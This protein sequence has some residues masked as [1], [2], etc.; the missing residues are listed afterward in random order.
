LQGGSAETHL[1]TA[2]PAQPARVQTALEAQVKAHPQV[3]VEVPLQAQVEV[4]L[5]AQVEV[6]LK[7]QV[8]V[9]RRAQV[10]LAP[11]ARVGT[12]P[13]GQTVRITLPVLVPPAT[14]ASALGASASGTL[15]EISGLIL[16]EAYRSINALV[17]AGRSSGAR[18]E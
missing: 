2:G 15:A 3:Q 4:P 16:P 7:A 8:E 14:I 1:G 5:K 12:A 13:Q 11:R 17:A 6:P 10:D 9:I 18:L